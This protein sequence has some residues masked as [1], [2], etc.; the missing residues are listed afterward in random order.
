MGSISCWW[1]GKSDVQNNKIVRHLCSHTAKMKANLKCTM[2]WDNAGHAKFYR[3][4]V[5]KC[6]LSLG[7]FRYLGAK[8]KPSLQLNIDLQQRFT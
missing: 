8:K 1:D 7:R 4:V 5:F 6:L 3:V 2:G